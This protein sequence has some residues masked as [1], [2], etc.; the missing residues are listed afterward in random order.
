MNFEK[1]LA[2]RKDKVIYKDGDNVVK[3]FSEK[4]PKSD[5]LNEALNH[6]RVE[7]TG[8]AIPEIRAVS[9]LDGKWAITLQYIE[10]KTL[11]QMMDEDPDNIEKYMND[12]VDL[13]LQV[14]SMRAPLLNKQ[15]D[16]MNR[17]ISSLRD[18]V[19]ATIRYELHTRVESMPKHAKVCHG[20]FNPSNIIIDSSG[21]AY[22]IDWSHATQGNASA[23][24]ARTYLL[25]SLKQ[26][27]LAEMYMN[28]FCEKSNTAKQYVQQWLPIVAATQMV[29]GVEEEK[30]LLSKWINVVDYE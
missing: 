29:K 26:P 2:E 24:A 17:K 4:Y 16:K 3:V 1:I 25:F 20:D 22:I 19:S 13:Q 30:E 6:A 27:E 28:L 11:Q 9:I 5:V 8:L 15:K 12:F 23:D 7:E 21:K 14:H 10:G 18:T